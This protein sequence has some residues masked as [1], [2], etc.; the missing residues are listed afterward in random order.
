MT[1]EIEVRGR[2]VFCFGF[3]DGEGLHVFD[4]LIRRE[5]EAYRFEEPAYLTSILQNFERSVLC[6]RGKNP[7]D[8][9]KWK[10]VLHSHEEL[11]AGKEFCGI[12][13]CAD[14]RNEPELPSSIP[15]RYIPVC[16]I[17]EV[18][19]GLDRHLEEWDARGQRQYVRFGGKDDVNVDF[20][21]T[22]E[23]I[24]YHGKVNDLSS[25]GMS[26]A[27]DKDTPL[28]INRTI[29]S[30]QLTLRGNIYSIT[31]NIFLQ[32]ALDDTKRLFVVMFDRRMP[33]EIRRRL[34]DFIH[35]SLQ[36]KMHAFLA[37]STT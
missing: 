29:D 20:S 2:K 11:C 27:F 8:L 33:G 12:I 3:T 32:R 18:E 5:Y 31:G 14:P 24:Q 15:W 6:I 19:R 4:Y 37:Q 22:V 25:A 21:F 28:Q 13:I 36:A 10:T 16:G 23:G 35:D 26:C 7:E 1:R 9:F 30:I 17:E 34:Q